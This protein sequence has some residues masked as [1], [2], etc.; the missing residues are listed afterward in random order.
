[1]LVSVK[2]DDYQATE[3]ATL[4]TTLSQ[5]WIEQ[6]QSIEHFVHQD[7]ERETRSGATPERRAINESELVS[8][9]PLATKQQIVERTARP[10]PRDSLF[11]VRDSLVGQK[12]P[13]SPKT[14]RA[15]LPSAKERNEKEQKAATE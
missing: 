1:M 6:Q 11:R 13:D 3:L 14:I 2:S 7:V 15:R 4:S 9:S 8:C 5:H 12:L 10:T